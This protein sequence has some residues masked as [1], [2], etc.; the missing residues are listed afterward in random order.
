[1]AKSNLRKDIEGIVE[2]ELKSGKKEV[3]F[4]WDSIAFFKEKTGKNPNTYLIE[5]G[6]K[7]A[8]NLPE[9]I[10]EEEKT[11]LIID[12]TSTQDVELVLFAGL[13]HTKEFDTIEELREELLP[14]LFN[15][16][17]VCA[18]AVA[19]KHIMQSLTKKK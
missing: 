18:V 12:S 10:T 17:V 14:H 7:S 11:R 3:K 19:G 1:M 8:Y 4:T 2:I 13:M 5:V 9:D 6:L 16:Y 15:D